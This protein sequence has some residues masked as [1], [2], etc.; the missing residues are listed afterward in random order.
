MASLFCFLAGLLIRKRLAPYDSGWGKKYTELSPRQQDLAHRTGALAVDEYFESLFAD[1]RRMAESAHDERR[2][3]LFS[4]RIQMVLRERLL[5][6]IPEYPKWDINAPAP[7]LR[8][9][10]QDLAALDADQQLIELADAHQMP[11]LLRESR[12]RQRVDHHFGFTH[13]VE[14]GFGGG[15]NSEL[16]SLASGGGGRR[17]GRGRAGTAMSSQ[18]GLELIPQGVVRL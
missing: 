4:G 6:A 5:R 15:D 18:D 10:A 9:L 16:R 17:R 7:H 12:R 1:I 11:E 2:L 14:D 13:T 3:F 8:A